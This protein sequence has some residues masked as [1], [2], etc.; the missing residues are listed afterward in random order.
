MYPTNDSE[1][2]LVSPGPQVEVHLADG[3]VLH[4]PRG[5]AVGRF[6]QTL[7]EADAPPIVGAIVNGELQGH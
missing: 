4:G 3:R 2:Q 7:P 6:L 5:A 1:I